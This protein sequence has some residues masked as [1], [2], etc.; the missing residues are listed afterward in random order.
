MIFKFLSFFLIF[1]IC[2]IILLLNK[3]HNTI[4]K[5][6]NLGFN[7][8]TFITFHQIPRT[9]YISNIDLLVVNVR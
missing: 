9:Y 3:S 7:G 4:F 2:Q 5:A 8:L 6:F 1:K